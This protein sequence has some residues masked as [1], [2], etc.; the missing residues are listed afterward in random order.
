MTDSNTAWL[1]M[2]W[3][4]SVEHKTGQRSLPARGRPGTLDQVTRCAETFFGNEATELIDNK[5]SDLT[6]TRNEATV[7]GPEDSRQEA[8]EPAERRQSAVGS[9][10]KGGVARQAGR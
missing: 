1:I 10:R 6:K 7:W 2:G 8:A 4:K 9:R 3:V 5:G